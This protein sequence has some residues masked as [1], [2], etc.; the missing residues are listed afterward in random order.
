MKNPGIYILTSPSGKKYVGKDSNLPRRAKEHLSG[1]N[2]Q[3]RHVHRAIKKYGADAFSVEIIQYPGISHEA[4]NAVERWKIRQLQTFSPKGYNLTEGGDSGKRSDETCQKISESNYKRV[5]D[6]THPFLGGELQQRNARKQLEDGT[7]P[8]LG[9][10]VQRR[11]IEDGTHPF[12]GGEMQ[13]EVQRKRVESGTHHFLGENNPSHKRVEDGTHNFLGKNN[14]SHKRLE[15]GTHNF[16][17]DKNPSHKRVADGTHNLLGKNNP[18]HKRLEDGTHNF[19]GDKNP[20]HKRV[21]DGTHNLLGKNQNVLVKLSVSKYKVVYQHTVLI[22]RAYWTALNSLH[23]HRK[24][25][26]E[27]FF[28]KDIPDTSHAEQMNLF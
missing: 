9:G 8:F 25:T 15:D 28:D 24:L 23:L 5:A 19:L 14:P 22:P 12:L 27:R 1:K 26:R 3:C 2:P 11:R 6:G 16:L 18:S 13:R 10:E 17:G 7:H 4:L 20:S 21:A